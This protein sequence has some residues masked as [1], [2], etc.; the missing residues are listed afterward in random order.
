M[1]YVVLT[2]DKSSF[3]PIT[4]LRYYYCYFINE[5]RFIKSYRSLRRE[6]KDSKKSINFQGQEAKVTWLIS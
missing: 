4:S 5:E 1:S 3:N 6:N 2:L